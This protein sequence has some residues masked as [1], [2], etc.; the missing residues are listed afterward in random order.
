VAKNPKHPRD[1]NQLAKLIVDIATGESENVKPAHRTRRAPTPWRR[2]VS[3]HVWSLAEV[4][5]L[6]A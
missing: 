1:P 2:A 6:T 4:G 3:D 5:G